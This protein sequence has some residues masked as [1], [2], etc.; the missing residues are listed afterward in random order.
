MK[1]HVLLPITEETRASSYPGQ[2]ES[3]SHYDANN[4]TNKMQSFHKFIT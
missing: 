3:I 4:S 2:D 1:P